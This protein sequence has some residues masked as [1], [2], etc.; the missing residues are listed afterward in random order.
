MIVKSQAVATSSTSELIQMLQ[1]GHYDV[2]FDDEAWDRLVTW[3]DLNVPCHGTWHEV[4]PFPF[5][6][7][8]RR[9]EYLKL[10]AGI[11]ED[12]EAIPDLPPPANA[13]MRAPAAAP[14]P[15]FVALPFV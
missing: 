14:P 1:K 9:L 12:Y 7:H 13:P 3:I 8:E 6:G 11:E 4:Y 2:R 10:Y 5:N 15:I